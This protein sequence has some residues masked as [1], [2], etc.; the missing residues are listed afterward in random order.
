MTFR[1]PARIVDA[2]SG[3]IGTSSGCSTRGQCC[4][5]SRPLALYRLSALSSGLRMLNRGTAQFEHHVA[6]HEPP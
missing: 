2:Q 5:Q 1:Q 6:R 3:P 4:T